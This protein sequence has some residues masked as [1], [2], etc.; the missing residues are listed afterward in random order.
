MRGMLDDALA[1][2]ARAGLDLARRFDAHAVA[3]ELALPALDGDLGVV[4]GS[5][6]AIW[7]TFLA[8]R[9]DEPDP[10]DRFVERCVEG[11]FAKIA[12]ARW[13]F[14]HAR[15]GETY[16][17]MQRIA[18]AAGLG[19]AS[20]THLVVHPIY[21][22]WIGLRAVAIVDGIVPPPPE[23]AVAACTCGSPCKDLLTRAIASNDWRDW[24]AVRDACPV[25]REHRYGDAQLSYHYTKD[26]R[27]LRRD[28]AGT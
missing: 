11:A 22:P 25:G 27:F 14:A 8:A 12:S 20:E 19:S 7:P 5:T 9:R 18:V 10:L 15:Y 1:E 23:T 21:G 26:P 6:R 13:Y 16:L 4:I 24:L 28:A 2:L 3:R 17:P